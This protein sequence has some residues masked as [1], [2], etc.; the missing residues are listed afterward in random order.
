MADKINTEILQRAFES[1]RDERAKGAN[2]A[3]R[4]GDAFLSLLAYAS[5][6]NGAYLSRE[7][8]DAAMG[9]ITFL[10]GLVSEGVA[11]L[12]QGAQF[13]GFVSGMAT[14][15]GAAI[16][17]DGNAEVESVKVRSYMQVL[18]LIV[19][20]LSAFEGDQF[21]T[22]SDTIEQVDDL[23]SGCYGLHLRSKYQG[24]FT[25]QHVN[26]VIKGMVNNLATATTS[27]TSASYYTSWMRINSVNAVQN[28]IE[29]TLYPDTEV[30]GGQNFPPCE[31]MNIARYG[32]QT[33]ESLQSCFYISSSEGRIVKLTGVTKPILD[34]YNYGM[35][36][37]DMPEFVKSLDLPIVKGR[38]Y[39]YA[40]GIITQDIIQIDYHGK[41]IVDFVDRG[42]WAEA[43]EYF[44]SALN[45]GTGKYETSDV[46][47][48]GCKWRCQK[49]GTHTAPRWNNTDWAMIE[50]NP[51]FTI[52]FLEDETL[53]DFDNFRAPLT[54]VATLY[55]QDI[56]S[57]ILD[58]DVAWTR[59]TENRA[60]EQRVTSDNI[61][62]LEVGS[63]AGK[64]IV[65]TQ[66]DLSI[67]SEGVPA[68][69][70]FTAT[71]TLRDGLGDEVAQDS[72]TLECV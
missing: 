33:D 63:K 21:F 62:S 49:T 8:D 12:N 26:N 56:T 5:Q 51:A 23:G 72:I 20:R 28:Y 36:F 18:E 45:P 30:P 67:D 11:H 25:A 27:S 9:L 46:W 37:G 34:D 69:I 44:C 14:G 29:V 64:A 15:K 3:R 2:T 7:H 39:L 71:V 4:I 16:D 6:D 1:I 17:G 58:S 61:W 22:E 68:K 35:V 41:P 52:D 57:D 40:A 43:A 19:N 65:L 53:Y 38:D 55:G 13:G 31:L 32:N 47:Y 24:Y 60:G 54:I 48:T 66:S 50:G 42:P 59:Y 10:K 70:R